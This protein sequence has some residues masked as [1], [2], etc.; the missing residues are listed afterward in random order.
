MG[1]TRNAYDILVENLKGRDK[2]KDLGVDGN[3]LEW[4]LGKQG[5][6]VWTDCIWLGIG[7]SGGI[8]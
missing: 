7:T 8:L 1:E 6:R 2:L 5:G 4:I 3:I